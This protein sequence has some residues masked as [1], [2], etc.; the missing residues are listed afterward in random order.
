[1][2]SLVQESNARNNPGT[3]RTVLRGGGCHHLA[4]QT[5]I[6]DKQKRNAK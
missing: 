1:M 3:K 4:V 5:H 6:Q 2:S